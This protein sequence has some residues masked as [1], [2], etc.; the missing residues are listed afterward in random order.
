MREKYDPVRTA[1]ISDKIWLKARARAR[2]DNVTMS[3]VINRLVEGY[4]K[5]AI[6][7]PRVQMVY[8]TGTQEK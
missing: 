4:A 5:G 6:T 3:T 1:R 8:D 2:K 7:L